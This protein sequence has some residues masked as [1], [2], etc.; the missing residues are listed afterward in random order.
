[1]L[2]AYVGVHLV[3]HTAPQP[4]R[5]EEARDILPDPR[6]SQGWKVGLSHADAGVGTSQIVIDTQTVCGG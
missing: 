6:C 5:P 2:E 4:K 3:A 1:M